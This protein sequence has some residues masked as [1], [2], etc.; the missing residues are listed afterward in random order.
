MPAAALAHNGIP[1]VVEIRFPPQRPGEV[2][3]VTDDLGLVVHAEGAN[4]W[5]CGSAIRPD[6]ILRGMAPVDASGATWLA[7]SVH[8]LFRSEDAG[9][10]FALVDGPLQQHVPARV[11]T[12]P[13]LPGEVLVTT[14]TIGLANDVFLSEDAGRTWRAAGLAIEGR[15]R[16][17]LL[18]AQANPDVVYVAH[19]DGAARSV[20]GGRTFRPM[21]LGPPALGVLPEEFY[22]LGDR[23]MDADEVYATIERFPNSIVV[24]S[25]D[26]GATWEPVLE[27]ED[28]PDTLSFDR[29]GRRGLIVTPFVGVFRTDDGGETWA[30]EPQ[31]PVDLLGCVTREPAS[32]RLW[33]C[34]DT[35]FM[36]PW[37]LGYSDDFGVSWTPVLTS[38]PELDGPMEC[39]AESASARACQGLCP[40]VTLPAACTDDAGPPEVDA[41]VDAGPPPP[42]GGPDVDALPEGGGGG[43][44]GCDVSGNALPLLPWFLLPFFRRRRQST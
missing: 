42:D 36:G 9:C 23:P 19:A 2:W 6:P 25:R 16:P 41:A 13:D 24:R 17:P 14:E 38:F 1:R 32:D 8:G 21:T 27:M 12:R 39:P 22:L 10:A 33:G 43:G 29:E 15:I 40:T 7:A 4:R 44:G 3:A 34:T 37:V 35:A 26:G 20:D 28:V 5:L 11:V 30:H 18:R 31:P